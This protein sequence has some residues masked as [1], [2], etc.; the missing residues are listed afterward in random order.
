MQCCFLEKFSQARDL[1]YAQPRDI[2][3]KDSE[4]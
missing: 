4:R 3:R 1:N 2:K